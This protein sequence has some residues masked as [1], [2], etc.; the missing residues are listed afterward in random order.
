MLD[1]MTCTKVSF[2]YKM[3]Y[4]ITTYNKC[5]FLCEV[6]TRLIGQIQSDEE[7]IVIDGGSTD[8][9]V[10]Y[11]KQLY[12]D[13]HIHQFISER[14]KGEA[15]GFNKG[16][17]MARGELIKVITD[18]DAFYWTGIQACKK[19]MLTHP[20]VD[21]LATD[22]AGTEWRNKDPFIYM[23]Y[24]DS[25]ME[26]QN[27]S[28]PFAFCGLGLLIRRSSLPLLGLFHIGFIRVDAEYSMRVTAGPANIAWYDNPLW[29]RI[30]NQDSNS[31]KY[32][33]Q[34]SR[35][36]ELLD[37]IYLHKTSLL[38]KIIRHSKNILRPIKKLIIRTTTNKCPFEDWPAT[39]RLCD[40][41]LQD[42]NKKKEG[43]FLYKDKIK[44]T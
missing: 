11:L 44:C 3:T 7:I 35:E 31:V 27:K 28:L 22:G 41:W 17:L 40:S 12:T 15:N 36:T 33:K 16:F 30:T 38:P 2:P 19:F 5:I 37:R 29:V 20:E 32:F 25:V 43:R 8:G 13:G 23:S 39:F 34:A 24:V 1:C 10:E 42:E 26:W 18:D 14:D 6:L 21:L 9:T 4:L